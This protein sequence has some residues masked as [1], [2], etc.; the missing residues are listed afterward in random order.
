MRAC[1]SKLDIDPE[2]MANKSFYIAFIS[3]MVKHLPTSQCNGLLTFH[4]F[5]DVAT[6]HGA[7]LFHLNV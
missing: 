3:L 4:Y 6:F 7:P 2:L 1:R 5:C